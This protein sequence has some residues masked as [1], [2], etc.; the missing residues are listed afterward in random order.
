MAKDVPA[1]A[2]VVGNPAQVV[3]YRFE[4]P[5]IDRLL[6]SEWWAYDLPRYLEQRPD[7]PLDDPERM[8]DLLTQEG[9]DIPR[10]GSERKSYSRRRNE[11]VIRSL[12]KPGT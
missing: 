4:Q 6:R 1:Y 11:I 7:I 8:L 3:K 12:A 9:G 10:I 5:L 2:I